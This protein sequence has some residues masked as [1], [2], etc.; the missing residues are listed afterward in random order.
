MSSHC[1]RYVKSDEIY[2][3]HI[4]RFM[5]EIRNEVEKQALGAIRYENILLNKYRIS[6]ALVSISRTVDLNWIL[7]QYF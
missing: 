6:H 7:F 3:T 2:S 1:I 4:R 5:V